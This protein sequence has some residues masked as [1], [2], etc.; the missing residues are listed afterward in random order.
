MK[1]CIFLNEP[2][3]FLT[4]DWL[5]TKGYFSVEL[6]GIAANYGARYVEV[7]DPRL[8][9]VVMESHSGRL[10]FTFFTQEGVKFDVGYD[11]EGKNCLVINIQRISQKP[12]VPK[13]VILDPG[14][15]GEARGA[16]SAHKIKGEYLWE[17]DVVLDIALKLKRLCDNSPNLQA[18]MTRTDDRYVSLYERVKFAEEVK[19]ELFISIHCNA[20]EGFRPTEARGVEFYCWSE[21]GSDYEAGRFL[22]QLENDEFLET[23]KSGANNNLKKILTDLLKE[24]LRKQKNQSLYLCQIL[25]TSFK[26]FPY[27]QRYNRGVKEARFKVLANYSM[28]AVLIETGFIS[29]KYEARLLSDQ[30]FQWTIAKAIFNGIAEYFSSVDAN[31]T[32]KFYALK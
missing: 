10:K 29:N 27:F 3:K 30:N 22:E 25:N 20:I 7:G 6:S 9:Q 8:S 19:G 15:G 32:P 23:V 14:H 12:S 26:K 5:S 4:E 24:E 2:V 31:F 28:P 1:F 21:R 11:S 16:R 18:F 17:K 13:K